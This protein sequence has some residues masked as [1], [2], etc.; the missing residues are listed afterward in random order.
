MAPVVGNM[1]TAVSDSD[2]KSMALYVASVM[3]KPEAEREKQGEQLAATVKTTGTGTRP[4]SGGTQTLAP[5]AGL[6]DKDEGAV[7]YAAA[8]ASCHESGRPVPYGGIGLQLSTAVNAETPRNL[9]NVVLNGLPAADGA[10]GPVMPGFAVAMH[11]QTGLDG[12]AAGRPS[13]PEGS[14]PCRRLVCPRSQT[15]RKPW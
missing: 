10:K 1:A 5:A 7:I 9:I 12:F 15:V 14:D 2:L 13:R 4:Q 3:G 8:C 6:A 11:D